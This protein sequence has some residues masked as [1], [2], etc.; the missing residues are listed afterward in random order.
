MFVNSAAP[1]PSSAVACLQLLLSEVIPEEANENRQINMG[2]GQ[3]KHSGFELKDGFQNQMFA[4]LAS[5]HWQNSDLP[6]WAVK[7]RAQKQNHRH[8]C[9]VPK[10]M[11]SPIKMNSLVALRAGENDF[12]SRDDK[13]RYF[14]QVCVAGTMT[15]SVPVEFC[16][17]PVPRECRWPLNVT[18]H[19]HKLSVSRQG[20]SP[21]RKGIAI[22]LKYSISNYRVPFQKRSSLDFNKPTL[23]A[24]ELGL[25]CLWNPESVIITR[26]EISKHTL[27]RHRGLILATCVILEQHLRKERQ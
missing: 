14:C 16:P 27:F 11:N 1:T 9:F 8:K 7:V 12:Y 17:L 2:Q 18:P 3:Q 5:S 23:S 21:R 4:S 24:A 13:T 20:R 15:L 26:V 25:R 22:S 6:G 19:S 10:I